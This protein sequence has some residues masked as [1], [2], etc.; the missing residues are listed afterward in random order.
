MPADVLAVREL[1][2]NTVLTAPS[3][4]EQIAAMQEVLQR[5]ADEFWMPGIS[6]WGNLYYPFS[7]RVGN[8]PETWIDGWI[9]GVQKITF[10]EQWVIRE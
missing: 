7:T 6:R 1:Y 9:E 10:P 4:D 8:I 2:D 3:T 5:A